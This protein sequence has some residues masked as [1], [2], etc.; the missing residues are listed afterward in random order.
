M[1]T[2]E[3]S[4]QPAFVSAVY[5]AIHPTSSPKVFCPIR[6]PEVQGS[7]KTRKQSA[8]EVSKVLSCPLN[9]SFTKEVCSDFTRIMCFYLTERKLFAPKTLVYGLTFIDVFTKTDSRW[10]CSLTHRLY[11]CLPNAF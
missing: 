4:S 6:D 1:I 8:N 3:V 10:Q 2:F 9:L 11:K 7:V 5:F